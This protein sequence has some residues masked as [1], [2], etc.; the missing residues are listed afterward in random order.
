MIVAMLAGAGRHTLFDDGELR[1]ADAMPAVAL[2]CLRPS[3]FVT[4]SVRLAYLLRNDVLLAH[5]GM[6]PC[7]F[8]GFF[9]RLVAN[10]SRA[11]FNLRR[12]SRGRMTGS[13]YPRSAAT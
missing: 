9:S 10:M 2:V 13:M 8:A 7:F 12:V 5:S 11:E 4:V 6:L 3:P 1:G